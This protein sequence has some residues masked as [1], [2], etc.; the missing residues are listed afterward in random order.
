M[1]VEKYPGLSSGVHT[2]DLVTCWSGNMFMTHQFFKILFSWSPQSPLFQPRFRLSS[3]L[4]T[5][6]RNRLQCIFGNWLICLVFTNHG[7]K[8]CSKF[9]VYV[10]FFAWF[11]SLQFDSCFRMMVNFTS[12]I[13]RPKVG[14]VLPLYLTSGCTTPTFAIILP[15][16]E[17]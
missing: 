15:N 8:H 12:L 11:K 1:S 3:T 14:F 16:V 10:F 2:L 13:W 5:L 17:T 7:I 9:K 6:P 4:L